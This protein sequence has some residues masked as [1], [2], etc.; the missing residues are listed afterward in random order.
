MA[1][2]AQ[3]PPPRVG[4]AGAAGA[5]E[6]P[7]IFPAY[8]VVVDEGLGDRERELL[9]RVR[10]AVVRY[11]PIPASGSPLWIRWREGTVVLEGRVRSLPLK[12]IAERLARSAAAD[13]PLVCELIADPEVAVAVAT[14]LALDPRTN[15]CP[16]QVHCQLGVVYL[17]GA[18]PTAEMAAAAAEIAQT[19]PG[20]ARVVNELTPASPS[21]ATA[22]GADP[23]AGASVS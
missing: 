2:A 8:P 1:A 11:T 3:S 12:A 19:V 4:A 14:A 18:V 22:A 6:A 16:V 5:P 13:Q 7:G 23:S 20:V 15:L 9:Y 10:D 21:P 17:R